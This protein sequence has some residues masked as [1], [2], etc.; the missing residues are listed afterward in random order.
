MKDVR[1]ELEILNDQTRANIKFTD[2]T[3]VTN[4]AFDI[5]DNCVVYKEYK[6]NMREDY[7]F[8]KA[9]PLVQVACLTVYQKEES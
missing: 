3:A 4:K 8:I 6:Y 2:N 5:K 7:A 9:V 1:E